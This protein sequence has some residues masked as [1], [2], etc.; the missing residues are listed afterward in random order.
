MRWAAF[1]LIAVLV[2]AFSPHV[3]FADASPPAAPSFSQDGLQRIGDYMRDEI[4]T[5][6]LVYRAMER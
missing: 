4:A 3:T 1:A 5:K 6:A 2:V